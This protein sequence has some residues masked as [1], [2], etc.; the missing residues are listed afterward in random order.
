MDDIKKENTVNIIFYFAYALEIFY[1]M[2]SNVTMI[3]GYRIIA[4]KLAYFLLIVCFI[5]NMTKNKKKDY[6]YI[7]LYI[8]I[9]FL[10][11]IVSDSNS[12]LLI[13]LFLIGMKQMKFKKIV[14]F[15]FYIKIIFLLIIVVLYKLNLT[16]NYYMYRTDGVMRSSMGFAHPNIFGTYIFLLCCEYIYI[17]YK[18]IKIIDYIVLMFSSF[19]VYYF[20]NSRTAQIGI[21]VLIILTFFYNKGTI[22]QLLKLKLI[23]GILRYLFIILTLMSYI[24]GILYINENQSTISINSLV[25]NRI[26]MIA[27]FIDDYDVTLFGNNLE[28]LGTKAALEKGEVAK[29]LDNSY[30]K[31]I[32]QYGILV[33]IMMASFFVRGIKKAEKEGDYILIILFT[34]FCIYGIM[35]NVLVLLQYNIFLLYFSQ[36]IYNKEEEN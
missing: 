24:L 22:Q 19:I 18:R 27:M 4:V 6:I 11:M 15:D 25:S 1:W 30:I 31:I 2:F 36:V 32:L 34:L 9:S 17:Y 3:G 26:K 29:V 5:L 28:L 35:E 16:E 20:S 13:I 10:S 7:G 12:I 33:Y 23:S 14:K 21:I 8:I